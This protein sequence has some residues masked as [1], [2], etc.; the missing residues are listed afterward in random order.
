[1]RDI[2]NPMV[3][4]SHWRHLEMEVKEFGECAGCEEP[5]LAGQD[6]YEIQTANEVIK[7][8]QHASCCMQFVGEI[9]CC[10]TAGDEG[11]G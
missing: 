6:Y 11:H 1:M 3:I 2:E 8:H 10:R 4:D 9:A 5:I 7:V